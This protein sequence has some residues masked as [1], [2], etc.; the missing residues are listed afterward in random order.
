MSQATWA[1]SRTA[2]ATINSSG[3]ATGVTAGITT[4]SAT[5][6]SVSGNTTLTIQPPPLAI[7]TTSLPSGAVS[8]AYTTTSAASGGIAPYAW[9]LAGGTLPPG[10]T[11]SSTGVITGTPTTTGTSSFTVRAAD[12]AFPS[13]RRP[14]CSPSPSTP[15]ARRPHWRYDRGTLTDTLW[16]A[17]PIN[18]GRYQ[19]AS[20]M[21]VSAVWSQSGSHR[22]QTQVRVNSSNIGGRPSR[23]W[24]HG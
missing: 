9:S 5:L 2:V 6:G 14:V 19:A 18:A 24:L 7:T 1:S 12:A 11:L 15:P 21:V 13:R 20:N 10:L 22:R 16:T 8:T 17:V 23:C 4:I 3:L